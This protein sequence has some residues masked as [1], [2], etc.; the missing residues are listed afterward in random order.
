MPAPSPTPH[1]NWEWIPTYTI[2]KFSNILL[3]VGD[4]SCWLFIHLNESQK[5]PLSLPSSPL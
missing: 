2:L 5:S 3:H 4:S 1:L